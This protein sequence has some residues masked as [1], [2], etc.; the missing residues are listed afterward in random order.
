M[1]R[2]PRQK[3]E[4]YSKTLNYPCLQLF[5]A[6]FRGLW[7]FVFFVFWQSALNPDDSSCFATEYNGDWEAW[8]TD[9]GLASNVTT[10]DVS[11]SMQWWFFVA[12]VL[13]LCIGGISLIRAAYGFYRKHT[14]SN[15]CLAFC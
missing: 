12:F 5:L 6:I 8:P 9:P 7:A 15:A 10:I 1:I 14:K 2:P 3:R 13:Q 11:G 4:R